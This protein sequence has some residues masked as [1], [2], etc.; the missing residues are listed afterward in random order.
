V[1][2][3]NSKQ[4]HMFFSE[5]THGC[6]LLHYQTNSIV[7]HAVSSAGV[8]GPWRVLDAPALTPSN[9]PNAWD[10]SAIHGP[11]VSEQL[12]PHLRARAGA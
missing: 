8:S 3:P 4:H 10:S 6:G 5:M 9:D 2:D 11:E 7:R 12:A 1:Y